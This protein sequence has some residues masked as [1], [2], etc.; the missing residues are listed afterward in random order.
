MIRV[1]EFLDSRQIGNVDREFL[2]LIAVGFNEVVH[3]FLEIED[4]MPE[5][6]YR[7]RRHFH[8]G[9]FPLRSIRVPQMNLG[10]VRIEPCHD[11]LNQD[12]TAAGNSLVAG[13]DFDFIFIDGRRS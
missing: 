13:R 12:V 4:Q 6:G 8:R 2:R 9:S 11:G 3:R 5:G 10:A 1:I 7:L